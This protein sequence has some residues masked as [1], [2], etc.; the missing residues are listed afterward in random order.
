MGAAGAA[1]TTAAVVGSVEMIWVGDGVGVGVG[2]TLG[3]TA[4]LEVGISEA[5]GLG[6]AE[7]EAGAVEGWL[8]MEGCTCEAGAIGVAATAPPMATKPITR[9]PANAARP[10]LRLGRWAQDRR[11]VTIVYKAVTRRKTKR[12]RTHTAGAPVVKVKITI[13]SVAAKP[14]W[15]EWPRDRMV[16]KLSPKLCESQA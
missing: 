5:D 15:V 7:I 10:I 12:S 4:G 3:D 2:V 9:H 13:S 16:F 6:L 8:E 11:P 1:G 14:T